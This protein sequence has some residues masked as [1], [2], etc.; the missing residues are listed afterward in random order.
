MSGSLQEQFINLMKANDDRIKDLEN[1]LAQR[2]KDVAE[3]TT[4]VQKSDKIITNLTAT[5]Q[6]YERIFNKRSDQETLS[7]KPA[8]VE[9]SEDCG[10]PICLPLEPTQV[11][12]FHKFNIICLKMNDDSY[13]ELIERLA[14]RLKNDQCLVLGV[15]DKTFN[16]KPLTHDLVNVCKNMNLTIDP[17]S[18]IYS[19]HELQRSPPKTTSRVQRSPAAKTPAKRTGTTLRVQR[20]IANTDQYIS[21]YKMSDGNY[22]GEFQQMAIRKNGNVFTAIGYYD[23]IGH[24]RQPMTKEMWT[25]CREV[26]FSIDDSSKFVP[27]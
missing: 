26:G 23:V 25:Y 12:A 8:P 21:M 27:M 3:L 9:E 18:P 2:E 14:I 16:I 4:S 15:F 22:M 5:I 19:Q 24:L 11:V 7:L 17:E 13:M 1:R 20:T 10:V 6:Y